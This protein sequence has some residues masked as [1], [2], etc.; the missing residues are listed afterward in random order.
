M[1]LKCRGYDEVFGAQVA[2][3]RP[4][5]LVPQNVTILRFGAANGVVRL[6]DERVVGFDGFGDL[7]HCVV[8][9]SVE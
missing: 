8:V 4:D 2:I 6:G 7:G 9:C 3:K 1:L 5:E